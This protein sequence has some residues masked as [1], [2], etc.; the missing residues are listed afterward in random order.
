MK[1]NLRGCQ[2]RFCPARLVFARIFLEQSVILCESTGMPARTE[3]TP[4]HVLA[5]SLWIGTMA[6]VLVVGMDTLG[7]WEE[8]D[9]WATAWTVRL[10]EGMRDVPA[11]MV[12]LMT[13]IHAYA[14]PLLMLATPQWWRRFILWV[15][16]TLLT[17]GWLPVLAL[18]SWK[19]PPSVPMIALF[20]SGLCAFIYAQRHRLPC[21]MGTHPST[22]AAVG[23]SQP[24]AEI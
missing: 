15:S 3:L 18:A 13:I 16:L 8:L 10:G 7:F 22:S 24:A 4:G 1:Q 6:L 23:D 9:T 20:W 12:V 17:A 11:S 2:K 5:P 14:L 19:L 21:E